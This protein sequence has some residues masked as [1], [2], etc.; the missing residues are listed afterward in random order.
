MVKVLFVLDGF[1]PILV[2]LSLKLSLRSNDFSLKGLPYLNL[3]LSES[4][5]LGI[6]VL[7]NFLQLLYFPIEEIDPIVIGVSQ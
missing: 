4:F 5:N 3:F 1:F 7:D 6:S 2:D